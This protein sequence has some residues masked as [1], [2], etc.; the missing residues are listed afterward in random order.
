MSY[1]IINTNSEQDVIDFLKKCID[2]NLT[3]PQT[4]YRIYDKSKIN[5][6]IAE[7]SGFDFDLNWMPRNLTKVDSVNVKYLNDN[8]IVAIF[9]NI[10]TDEECDELIKH[11]SNDERLKRAKVV[12]TETEQGVVSPIR[13]NDLIKIDYLENNIVTKLEKTI[14]KITTVPAENGE[15]IQLLHYQSDE[16]YLAHNDFFDEKS[17]GSFV[18]KY[19]QRIATIIVY[20]NDNEQGGNTFFPNLDINV[21]PKKGTALYFEYTNK[22]GISTDL[23]KHASLPIVDGEKWALV[24]WLRVNQVMNN[25]TLKGYEK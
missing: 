3:I 22:N 11:Y 18:E 21:S 2:K 16:H 24:K 15:A 12:S 1:S 13:T 17:K 14:E 8:P 5:S 23:C 25:E 20:L 7:I 10:L 6:W 9:E 19:G 4:L